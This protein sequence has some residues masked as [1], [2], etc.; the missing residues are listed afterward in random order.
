MIIVR[1]LVWSR[2]QDFCCVIG[3]IFKTDFR[4]NFVKNS[5]PN[6]S[7]VVGCIYFIW[8]SACFE[9]RCG[10]YTPSLATTQGV[11]GRNRRSNRNGCGGGGGGDGGRV[12]GRRSSIRRS[13][14][15]NHNDDEYEETDLLSD[16]IE[17]KRFNFL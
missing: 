2:N 10:G 7:A 15:N 14:T 16:Q 6:T 13:G 5:T 3:V 12:R 1:L 8:A 9:K 17:Y 4:F 11:C